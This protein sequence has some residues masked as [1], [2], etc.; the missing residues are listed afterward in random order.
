MV[1]ETAARTVELGAGERFSLPGD[2]H[3]TLIS[4]P[5]SGLLELRA[6]RPGQVLLNDVQVAGVSE[7]RSGDQLRAGDTTLLVQRA[8]VREP[9][10]EPVR[11]TA[12]QFEARVRAE[13]RRLP[14]RGSLHLGI[15]C[16]VAHLAWPDSVEVC[17]RSPEVTFVLAFDAD[18]AEELWTRITAAGGRVG[19]AQAPRDGRTLDAMWSAA[20]TALGANEPPE[21]PFDGPIAVDPAMV[22]LRA[23]IERLSAS[24]GAVAFVG[25]PGS[26]RARWAFHLHAHSGHRSDSLIRV[27]CA[28]PAANSGR[29]AEVEPGGG[30][31]LLESFDALEQSAQ[32]A[33]LEALR[34]RARVL[35]TV[36]AP[37]S[38]AIRE[39]YFRAEL[40]VPPLRDRPSEVLAHAMQAVQRA[41][42]WLGRRALAL[43][44]D[45]RAAL[46]AWD[47][48]GNVRELRNAVLLGALVSASDELR[49]EDL[50][51][52]VVRA[53]R[54]IQE[55]RGERNFRASMRS[56]EKDALLEVLGRT[57]WNV[58]QA[59]R[60][61]GLPRRTVVYRMGRLGLRRPSR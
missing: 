3:A 7:L 9:R 16:G 50:P 28:N 48:P 25:E 33:R 37:L 34:G 56:L 36:R 41:R 47:W 2:V 49:A 8:T 60:E 59:A 18:R 22:R 55:S 39:R 35:V 53:W 40:A 57:H 54:Q 6:D 27:D 38:E 23:L 52:A 11:W 19:F 43:N 15:A 31:V 61:L 4:P 21:R 32:A 13:L 26:G 45:A 17:E 29:H 14:P 51:P 30:T 12:E 44:A 46:Q 58:T 1:T 42:G 10:P 5:G 24:E 20:L